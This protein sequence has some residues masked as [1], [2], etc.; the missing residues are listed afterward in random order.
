MVNLFARSV[1]SI[2]NFIVE[3]RWAASSAYSP[4]YSV[5]INRRLKAGQ[6]AAFA[7]LNYAENSIYLVHATG[8]LE[9][10]LWRCRFAGHVSLFVWRGAP[11]H[12]DS[13]GAQ[14]VEGSCSI[15]T[16]QPARRSSRP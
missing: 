7:G 15:E 5:L 10:H 4:G 12:G 3:Y 13:S 1:H 11:S 16:S 6:Q 2:D 14:A 8:D 9:R